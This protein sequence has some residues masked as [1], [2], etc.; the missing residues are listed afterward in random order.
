MAGPRYFLGSPLFFSPWKSDKKANS[1]D[2]VVWRAMVSPCFP[3]E[4]SEPIRVF[5]IECVECFVLF[6]KWMHPE[7]ELSILQE[8][9]MAAGEKTQRLRHLGRMVPQSGWISVRDL[10]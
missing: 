3:Q 7:W 2:S 4:N 5:L 6:L 10:C 1:K 8:R 9:L